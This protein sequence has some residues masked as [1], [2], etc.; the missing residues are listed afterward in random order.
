MTSFRRMRF[1]LVVCALG[2][3]SSLAGAAGQQTQP[4]PAATAPLNSKIPVNAETTVGRLANGLRYYIRA[5]KEPENRAELRLVVN[6]GSVLEDNDQRGLAHFVEHM[7]FNGTKHFPKNDVIDFMQSIGMRFGHDVNAYTTSDETVYMLQVP[8][9]KPAIVDKALLV[10]EDWAHDVTFDPAEIEKERGVITEE[11]RLGRGAG[12][13]MQDKQLPVLL[14]G[15]RYADRLP[16]GLM[17]VVQHATP[18][19]LTRF[20]SDWYRPDLMAVVAVGDFDRAN[21]ETLIKSHFSA[22]PEPSHPRPR[23]V[24]T[25]PDHSGTT[26]AIATD[27]EAASTTVSVYN[28]RP[29]PDQSTVREYRQQIVEGLFSS[30]LSDRLEEIAQKPDAPFIG[31][32]AGRTGIVRTTDAAALTAS[33]KPDGIDRGLRALFTEEARVA[34]FGFTPTEL[35]REKANVLRS[36]ELLVAE[37][38]K[39]QSATL[40]AELIRN[41]LT[42]EP[43][44]GIVYE[45]ELYKRFLP[46]ITL[47]E[48]D[49][50]AKTWSPN[51]DRVV[52]VNA[53]DRPD[54]TVPTEA[55]LAADMTIAPATTLTPYVDTVNLQPL[56]A[57]T[58]AAGTIAATTT[59]DVHGITEWTLS[60]GA[61]VI[62]KPTTFKEDEI[63]MRAFSPGGDSLASDSDYLAASTAA[64]MASAGGLGS[65]SEEDLKKVL[66]GKA[67]SVHPFISGTDEGVNGSSSAKDLETLFQLTYLTF[68]A[69]R[70]DR[71]AFNVILASARTALAGQASRPEYAFSVALASA[72]SQDHLRARP[73]TVD[74]LGELDLDKSLAFYK[75]RFADASNFTFVLVGSFDLATMRP[76]V[77]R[78]LA[79]LPATHAHETWRD[80]GLRT[81]TAV[82]ERE[83][84]KGIDPKSEAAIVFSGPFEYDQA[85]RSVIRAMAMILEN[86][87]RQALRED[88]SGTYAQSA[89]AGYSKIPIP[90]YRVTISFGS[91][92]DRTNA[93]VDRTF[94]EI[95]RLKNDGPTALEVENT[96]E[97]L[98]RDYENSSR[99]NGFYLTEIAAREENGESLANLFALPDF[100]NALTAGSIQAAA[101]QYLDTTRYV[102]VVLFPDKK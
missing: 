71:D 52:L 96:K 68:T 67:A 84:D 39:S 19:R 69:P 47:A 56:V 43:I 38:D 21:L 3:A 101:R 13:R 15:S 40:A 4:P 91:A 8:T 75:A 89:S 1:V 33:V 31:A 53:P 36:M 58:P 88:L 55:T 87:L 102:K 42:T 82:V 12:A 77:E 85:H 10:L 7:A 50:L 37:K 99:E 59:D 9:D 23:P 11:W 46:E 16:I 35:A 48:I 73:M 100:Y 83:V 94:Q 5:N 78:Y 93:L 92:P 72:L 34:E 25:V 17:D 57:T 90:Q 86:R 51:R 79:S 30:M 44:P 97:T 66:A 14:K 81:P 62:L 65:F 63:L 76:F 18:D 49:A 2:L 54:V 22:I 64:E 28:L 80:V 29:A 6:A 61:R 24:V 70:T 98:L 20:Y 26:Y 45:N 74:R 27:K 41:F 60:N 95:E 32:G